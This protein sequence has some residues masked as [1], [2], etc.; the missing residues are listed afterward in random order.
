MQAREAFYLVSI[1]GQNISARLRGIVEQITVHD[2]SGQAADTAS[3]TLDDKGGQIKL[4][5]KNDPVEISLGWMAGDVRQVFDGVI[6]SVESTGGRGQGHMLS[7]SAKSADMSSKI[8][9]HREKNWDDKTLGE[10][11]AEA[12]R[13]AGIQVTVHP[14]LAKIK[15]EYWGMTN[16]S[17]VAFGNKLARELGGT[18]KIRNGRA[19]LVPRNEGVGAGGS[20]L[21]PIMATVGDNVISWSISPAEARPQFTKYGTRWF[22]RKA[23]KW[24]RETV[25]AAPKAQAQ[26]TD[27]YSEADAESSKGRSGSAKRGGDREKGGGTITIDGDSLAQ[28]E[29]PVIVSGTRPGIDG[30]YRAESVEHRYTRGGGYTCT[31]DIKSPGEDTGSDDRKPAG[32]GAGTKPGSDKEAG[33]PSIGNVA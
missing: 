18:F 20:A 1:A 10:V 26:S 28:A 30:T 24:K 4:P 9:E 27:R 22:D 11:L 29:A 3:I 5:Q 7:I 8:K 15:R 16:Q 17:F 31:I 13:F 32:K 14:S 23:A 21:K 33:V 2:G 19:T 6:D 25:E 12:G